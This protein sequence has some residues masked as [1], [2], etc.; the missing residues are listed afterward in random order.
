[1]YAT[2]TG[3]T[4]FGGAAGG[5]GI[6][7]LAGTSGSTRRLMW[8]DLGAWRWEN[9]PQAP[10]LRAAEFRST[11][12]IERP[13]EARARF[14]PDGLEGRIILPSSLEPADAIVVTPAGRLGVEF[15]SDGAFTAAAT[16]VLGEEQFLTAELMGDEQVRR[17]RIVA[18][19]LREGSA[20]PNA[21]QPML[22]FWT[23]PWSA[24]LQFDPEAGLV[25]S[26]LVVAP[27][28]FESPPPGSEIRLPAPLLVFR[29]ALGPDGQPPTGMFDNQRRQWSEKSSPT[30]TWLRF[31]LPPEVAPADVKSVEVEV[32]VT[33]PIGRLELATSVDGQTMPVGS[34]IDP[35]GA[36][37]IDV[38]DAGLLQLNS[39]GD[40][41]LRIAAGDPERP[42]LTTPNP[43]DP[44]QVSYWR[45][46][47][48]NLEMQL[49]IPD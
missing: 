4:N 27:L 44:A 43:E 30:A 46:E 37:S 10:G 38:D 5:W 39:S 33:G 12:I 48:L 7:D 24:G 15:G 41:Y 34:W 36:V 9:L 42:E 19:V 11:M 22:L 25:G 8:T 21:A 3:M 17:S 14:G 13:V 23:K 40:F 16:N 1:M 31:D 45:I 26:A 35:V 32:R 2:D 18:N 28:S 6:P 47:S 49:R 29:E 20:A